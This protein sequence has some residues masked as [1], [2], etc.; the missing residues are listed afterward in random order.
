MK[1]I[2][3]KINK[4]QRILIFSCILVIFA[5]FFVYLGYTFLFIKNIKWVSIPIGKF[6]RTECNIL[7]HCYQQEIFITKPFYI[8]K[9]EVTAK[10]YK[11]CVDTGG[12]EYTEHNTFH[13]ETYNV[14]EKENH[15]INYLN[16]KNVQDYI[17]WK[18]KE[19]RVKVRLCTEAEWEYAARANTNTIYICGNHNSCLND[20][21]WYGINSGGSTHKVGEKNPNNWG[22]YDMQGNVWELTQDWFKRPYSF[23]EKIDPK[24]PLYGNNKVMRGSAYDSTELNSNKLS[25][26]R[27]I[28]LYQRFSNTGFRLC[29]SK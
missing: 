15:P 19:S 5:S 18:S 9:F 16:W 22:L 7:G 8:N 13:D 29:K 10:E 2:L 1:M 27:S 17:T 23:D 21:A 28:G 24:G 25:Y 3:A 4:N 26:R 12:C 11:Q 20:V 6:I 14:K